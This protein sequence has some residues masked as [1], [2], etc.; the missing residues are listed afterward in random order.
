[1]QSGTVVRGKGGRLFP[2]RR[3]TRYLDTVALFAQ[4]EKV[5][6]KWKTSKNPISLWVVEYRKRPK[7]KKKAMYP[8]TRPDVDNWAKGVLD[9]LQFIAYENDSQVVELRLNKLY[10]EDDSK[11]HIHVEELLNERLHNRQDERV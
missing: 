10:T 11:L 5:K 8:T 4:A 9:A 1:M 6:R 3:N 7:S 2:Q